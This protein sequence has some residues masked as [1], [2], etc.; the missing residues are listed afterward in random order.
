MARTPHDTLRGRGIATRPAGRYARHTVEPEPL[1]TGVD[2]APGDDAGEDT[3]EPGPATE[4]IAEPIR[5]II[6]RNDSPDLPFRQSINPYRGCEHGCVYC[7]ARPSHAWIDLSRGLD[8]EQKIIYKPGAP[9]QLRRELARPG[10]A[11]QPIALGANTD[12]WQ[13]AERRLGIARDIL[14]VLLEFGHPV[15]IVTKSALVERDL[16]LLTALAERNLV[17]VWVSITTLDVELK[18]RMEPR[19]AGPGRRLAVIRN[20]AAAGVPCGVMV[21]PVIPALNDHEVEAILEA[22]AEAG[23]RDAGYVPVRLPHE[24][25]SL[26]EAWLRDHYPLRAERVL[27]QIRELRG[28]RLND[29]RFGSR[30]RGEGL[31]AD[32]LARRF[33]TALRRHGY[34]RRPMPELDTGVFRVPA[35]PGTQLSL[36]PGE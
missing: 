19:A 36:L 35:G 26:F 22:A 9:E 27:N 2:Q 25:E 10:Y 3:P 5:R 4:L 1:E 12:A 29:P 30:M 34:G 11:C 32:L 33:A 21:A 31:Y 24:V 6:S 18:R 23:A 17:A 28:G 16:D 14:A 8:F 13:P 20:L 7:Y 15:T